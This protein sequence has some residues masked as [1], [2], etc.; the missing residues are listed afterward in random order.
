MHGQQLSRNQSTSPQHWRVSFASIT[1]LLAISIPSISLCGCKPTV[2]TPPARA[3][4]PPSSQLPSQ[5]LSD[6]EYRGRVVRAADVN[7]NK[8]QAWKNEGWNSIV[9]ELVDD[10]P[11]EELIQAA[12]LIEKFEMRLEYFIEVARSPKLAESQ[13]Q[14]MASLQGHQEWRR[15]YPDFP[16]LEPGHVVKTWPWVPIVYRGAFDAQ[17]K[18]LETLMASLPT[19]NRI[20]LH[21][22]Q[23]GP[24]CCGCGHPLCRWTGDYGPIHTAELM[25]DDA[26][27]QFVKNVQTKFPTSDVV[28]IWTIECEEEDQHDVCGGVG[29][30]NGICWKAWNK[31]LTPL[32]NST[33]LVGVSCFYKEYGRDLP[34]YHTPAG[35]IR[36]AIEGFETMRR[37]HEATG[38]PPNRLVAVLQGWE[39]SQDEVDAQ[40]DAAQAAK[41]HGILLVVSKQDQSWRPKSLKV[42]TL[43]A[44]QDEGGN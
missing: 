9:L 31:Q 41:T 26:A 34:R 25:G 19:P 13:P 2:S 35:W 12:K 36:F 27:S 3:I 23:G 6:F 10:G 42:S 15:L 24:S 18:R 32:A 11:Q 14:L 16:E 8:L 40:I 22:L 44:T 17:L 1:F 39:V 4:A 43:K 33:D 30:Y 38:L 21:D 5:E 7:S 29:C 37:K 20:W 28:P